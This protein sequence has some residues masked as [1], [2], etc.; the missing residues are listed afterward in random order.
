MLDSYFYRFSVIH[1]DIF[2]VFDRQNKHG[3]SGNTA[4]R[5]VHDII[6]RYTSKHYADKCYLY[7]VLIKLYLLKDKIRAYGKEQKRQSA[8]N[9]QKNPSDVITVLQAFEVSGK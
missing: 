6:P 9:R 2:A 3:I 5:H 7:A 8:N 4:N 1:I